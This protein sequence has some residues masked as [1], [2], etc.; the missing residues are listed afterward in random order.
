MA[1]LRLGFMAR[2]KSAG[3]FCYIFQTYTAASRSV[4]VRIKV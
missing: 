2:V 3:Y 1:R 4:H